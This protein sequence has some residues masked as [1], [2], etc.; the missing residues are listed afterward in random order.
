MRRYCYILEYCTKNVTETCLSNTSSIIWGLDWH[1]SNK[2]KHAVKFPLVVR[3]S[4]NPGQHTNCT[5]IMRAFN[6]TRISI[7]LATRFA[8]HCTSDF[9][10]YLWFFRTYQVFFLRVINVRSVDFIRTRQA[11]GVD[12]V[13]EYYNN[14]VTEQDVWHLWPAST[15]IYGWKRRVFA[16]LATTASNVTLKPEIFSVSVSSI[17]VRTF[18]HTQLQSTSR[19]QPLTLSIRQGF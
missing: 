10:P 13:R 5:I 6:E 16:K 1:T 19:L 8:H 18:V 11:N 9:L 15:K 7:V 3:V 4:L 12:E 14:R 17:C 2:K